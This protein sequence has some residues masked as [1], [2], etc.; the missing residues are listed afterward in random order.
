[1]NV[2]AMHFGCWVCHAET[3]PHERGRTIE[4]LEAWGMRASDAQDAE[5]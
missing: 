2:E 4:Q 5:S 1:M 3:I